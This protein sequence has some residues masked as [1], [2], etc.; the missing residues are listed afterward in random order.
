M[1][2]PKRQN[3][4]NNNGQ[5]N[6]FNKNILTSDNMNIFTNTLRKHMTI[7]RL[8]PIMN[9]LKVYAHE[10]PSETLEEHYRKILHYFW[11][12][13]NHHFFTSITIRYEQKLLH[14]V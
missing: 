9:I 12:A 4:F 5:A 13:P 2:S 7:I 3:L 11:S 8:Y 1:I 10:S 6:E 14:F